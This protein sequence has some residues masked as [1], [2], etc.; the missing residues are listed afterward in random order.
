MIN[1]GILQF[2]ENDITKKCKKSIE[3]KYDVF[4]LEDIIAEDKLNKLQ[5]IVAFEN[6]LSDLTGLCEMILKVR[7]Q[8]ECYIYIISTT[9]HDTGKLI[10]L[11]LGADFVFSERYHEL[12]EILLVMNSTF[13]RNQKGI[14]S[15]SNEEDEEEKNSKIRLIPSNSSVLIEGSR[16][17]SLTRLEYQTLNLLAEKP[18]I[19][20]S[21]DEI[22]E[23]L[24]QEKLEENQN[25]R[26]ANI[27]F[28]LRKK[29][30]ESASRP[31]YIKTVRSKGYMLDI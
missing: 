31:T 13:S 4:L 29:I 9:A 10:Y 2:S 1:I 22:Y 15:L 19:A 6:E 30:E 7:E 8:S 24:Y 25:Y 23:E 16:E 11:R 3:S 21:Y 26:V 27:I 5:A 17:V 28:H 18:K 14:N 20:L 12:E